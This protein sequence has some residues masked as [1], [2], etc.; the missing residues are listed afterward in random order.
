MLINPTINAKRVQRLI[1]KTVDGGDASTD[2]ENAVVIDGGTA[3]DTVYD[4][5]IDG[6]K[7]DG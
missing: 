3:T 5:I 2:T 7:S 4:D 6:G 1:T